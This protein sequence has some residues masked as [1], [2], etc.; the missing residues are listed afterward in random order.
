[1]LEKVKFSDL[2]NPKTVLGKFYKNC[3][4][5]CKKSNTLAL[6]NLYKSIY[7]GTEYDDI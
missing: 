7:K 5:N 4:D 3:F 6:K 2:I 1:M